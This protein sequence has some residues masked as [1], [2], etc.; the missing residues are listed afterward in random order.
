MSRI[1]PVWLLCLVAAKLW[2]RQLSVNSGVFIPVLI[3]NPILNGEF[4]TKRAKHSCFFITYKAVQSINQ[5]SYINRVY[6]W[7][8][9]QTSTEDI[10]LY[11]SALGVGVNKKWSL[12][13][14]LALTINCFHEIDTDISSIKFCPIV[15]QQIIVGM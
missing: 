9:E 10:L 3:K 5:P 4:G 7:L 8:P 1:S 14:S 13:I 6:F 2:C 12:F 15:Y 11:V